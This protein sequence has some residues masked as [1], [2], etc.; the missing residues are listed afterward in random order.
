MKT[1][2]TWGQYPSPPPYT[3]SAY[4]QM[5]GTVIPNDNVGKPR[6]KDRLSDDLRNWIK[7]VNANDNFAPREF[8][9]A[10]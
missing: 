4:L 3:L 1:E 10:A 8:A 7:K 2:W 6:L 9:L 5:R